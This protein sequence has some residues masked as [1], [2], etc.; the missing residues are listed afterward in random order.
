MTVPPV[1]QKDL[2]DLDIDALRALAREQQAKM[3][4]Q[5]GQISMMREEIDE[6]NRGVVA[7]Y[8]ELDE[9]AEGLRRA[10]KVSE[11]RFLA[12]Y[13]HA[14]CG[15]ALIDESGRVAENNPALER[16]LAVEADAIRGRELRDFADE[17]WSDALDAVSRP[18]GGAVSR[19]EVS[20]RRRDGA[21]ARLEWSAS[22]D[23]EEGLALALAM[24]V[25]QRAEIERLRVDWLERERDAR[26]QAERGSRM[27][28]DFMSVLAHELRAPLNV[29][30]GWAQVF[31]RTAPEPMRRGV[32]AIERA[33]ATQARLIAD[34]LDVSRLRLG[35][36]A[37]TFEDVD[38]AAE[39]G[40]AVD[41]L[42]ATAE[43][44]GVALEIRVEGALRRIR[45]D[46]T[47]LQQVVWNLVSNAIKFTPSG[48][49]VLAEV[50]ADAERLRIAI[51]DNGQG[52]DAEFLPRVFERFSQADAGTNR[53]RG[54]L[55]LGMSIVKQIVEAHGGAIAAA[56]AGMGLGSTFSVE[57]P[58]SQAA[59]EGGA[60]LD[61]DASV[62]PL[63]GLDILIVDDDDE[64]SAVLTT[65]LV[66]RGATVRA[67][68]NAEAALD[69]ISARLPD[70]LVSDVGMPGRDGYALIREV[71]LRDSAAGRARMPAIALTAFGRDEDRRDAF[72]AGFDAH[73]TKPMRPL[74]IVRQIV[75]LAAPGGRPESE[76]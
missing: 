72:E 26:G 15:I 12:V 3:L 50:S 11:T 38:P 40:H 17:R 41:T 43:Q 7:L 4:D 31:K 57:L 75:L 62:S 59:L 33:C 64:A 35:K 61:T 53:Q 54:G 60:A 34:L 46:P 76:A 20:M 32:E 73:L 8:A 42:R 70:V 47:R 49:R 48:G 52:M 65:V 1:P 39:V 29:V 58:F 2:A 51:S 71:R 23:V 44:A 74:E 14:P 9:Q 68:S 30:S 16:M 28:D 10:K 19:R 24:D 36:L 45:A 25:S 6:T 5:E 67:A 63:A 22:A 66:D 18:A 27:K 21:E 55:G 37:M 56:S 69:M 13:E